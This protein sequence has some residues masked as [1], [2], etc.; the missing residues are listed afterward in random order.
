MWKTP[1]PP[2]RPTWAGAAHMRRES[3]FKRLKVV[4]PA[5]RA[6]FGRRTKERAAI[7]KAVRETFGAQ[8]Q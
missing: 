4:M 6:D 8:V 7:K 1:H 3:K 2:P 5:K